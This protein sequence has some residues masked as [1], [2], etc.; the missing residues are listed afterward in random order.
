METKKDKEKKAFFIAVTDNEG[1]DDRAYSNFVFALCQ[2][3]IDSNEKIKQE[4]NVSEFK[5]HDMLPSGN[6]KD[7][8]YGAF[9][10]YDAF[11]VLLDKMD[12]TYNPNVW[13]ELGIASTQDKPIVL[14]A[15]DGTEIPFHSNDINV[16]RIDQELVG[17]FSKIESS[18]RYNSQIN[19]IVNNLTKNG[20]SVSDFIEAFSSRFVFA[21]E[22]GSPFNRNNDSAR[23]KELGFGSLMH[24]FE[25]SEII[26][27]I[28]NPA[29]RADYF[30]GEEDAFKELI[31][32]VSQA[33]S[34]L[35]TSRFANQSIVAGTRTNQDLH[36]RFM[37]E[38]AKAS[39]RVEKCDRIICNNE[40]LK[41]NDVLDVL[42]NCGDIQVFIRKNAYSIGFELVIIDEKVAFI[43]F[44]QIDRTGDKDVNGETYEYEKEV[45]NSTLKIRGSSVCMKLA[46]IFDRLHHRDFDMG[47]RNPSRTLLGVPQKECLTNDE[48][49]RGVFRLP[50]QGF[51]GG[52]EQRK[53][54]RSTEV[55]RLFKEAFESWGLDSKDKK[56]M[57]IG[58][59]LLDN[60]FEDSLSKYFSEAEIKEIATEINKYQQN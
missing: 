42:V 16:I 11:V 36:R 5:R 59:C 1:S 38:L 48:K 32:E 6:L 15:Q 47:C 13:F 12:R 55:I 10:E 4:Y 20:G 54:Q 40:P 25:E 29:V 18:C 41:W 43:H 44:Y 37:T 19:S 27:L 31:K 3:A 8:I 22:N 33:Q 24:L 21:M 50:S 30:T 39:K 7:S 60:H 14:I 57:A 53:R 49:L 56:N 46:N 51:V 45:I 26:E 17:S 52:D 34:S 28:K 35:R 23:I 58:I 2:Y 9:I